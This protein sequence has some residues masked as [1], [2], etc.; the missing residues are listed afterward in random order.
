[1]QVEAGGQKC[2]TYGYLLPLKESVAGTGRMWRES[3]ESFTLTDTQDM[4]AYLAAVQQVLDEGYTPVA[5]E[6][7]YVLYVLYERKQEKF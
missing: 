4:M 2:T 3:K 1:M 5:R 6:G 7:N